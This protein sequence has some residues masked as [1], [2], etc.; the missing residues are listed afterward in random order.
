MCED[1]DGRA[2]S[3]PVIEIVRPEAVDPEVVVYGQQVLFDMHQRQL[4][5]EYQH[6]LDQQ[7]RAPG[8][9]SSDTDQAGIEIQDQSESGNKM[10]QEDDELG[11]VE[12]IFQESSYKI[13]EPADPFPS[14]PAS[15]PQL[16][17][18]SA[19]PI[20]DSVPLIVENQESELTTVERNSQ[21]LVERNPELNTP[22]DTSI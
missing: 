17:V 12:D 6:Y 3:G 4:Q 18:A 8:G 19:P 2:A 20:V 7:I 1:E 16:Y 22:H 15:S 10:D 5:L 21:L 11:K 9:V 14:G 13:E